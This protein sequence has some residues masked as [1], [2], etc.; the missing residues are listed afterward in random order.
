MLKVVPYNKDVLMGFAKKCSRIS[1]FFMLSLLP[2]RVPRM[3]G[4]ALDVV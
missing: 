2:R 4:G 1:N 3:P